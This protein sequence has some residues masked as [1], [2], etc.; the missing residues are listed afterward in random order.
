MREPN[1]KNCLLQGGKPQTVWWNFERHTEPSKWYLI[2]S[3]RC[4]V[5]PSF[6]YLIQAHSYNLWT[7][8]FLFQET[9][10]I[11]DLTAFMHGTS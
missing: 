2:P 3:E 5:L 9:R 11:K 1:A 6:F 8:T 10:K 4:L 7:S